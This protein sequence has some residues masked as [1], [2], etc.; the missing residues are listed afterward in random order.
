MD[1]FSGVSVIAAVLSAVSA[2]FAWR[3]TNKAYRFNK[4]LVLHKSE[5]EMIDSLIESLIKL[6][7]VRQ[8][9]PLEMP[10]D[11]FLNTEKLLDDIKVKIDSICNSNKEVETAVKSWS[12][13]PEG[14]I[15]TLIKSKNSWEEIKESDPDFL[16][17]IIDYFKIIKKDLLK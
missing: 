13:K 11:D 14:R 15:L 10:D 16:D 1:F 9:N 2:F 8:L 3:V 7:S 6:K 17:G 12:N 5:L 4:S